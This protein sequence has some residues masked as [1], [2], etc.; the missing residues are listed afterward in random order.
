MGLHLFFRPPLAAD[1]R[2]GALCRCRRR[3]FGQEHAA[4]VVKRPERAAGKR[5]YRQTRARPS[6]I[7]ASGDCPGR[8]AA[9]PGND[10]GCGM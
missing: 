8:P 4:A 1:K 5:V 3:G 6:P 7:R 10:G 2:W 9:S